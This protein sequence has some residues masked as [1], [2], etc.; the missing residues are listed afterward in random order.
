MGRG[1]SNGWTYNLMGDGGGLAE[2]ICDLNSSQLAFLDIPN[3]FSTVLGNDGHLVSLEK[4][5]DEGSGKVSLLLGACKVC[6][7]ES[8][9]RADLI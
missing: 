9:L 3:N 7:A 5:L 2:C 1:Y 8:P 6:R 4:L